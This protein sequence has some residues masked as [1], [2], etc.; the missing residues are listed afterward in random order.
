MPKI[1]VYTT[2]Y[3]PY[4]AAAKTL[5]KNK[6]AKFEE[7]NVE[8]NEEKR[9]WLRETTGQMTVPQIFI[10]DKPIGGYRELVGLEQKGELDGLLVS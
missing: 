2:T 10:N 9:K 7:I 5:L 8:G 4:C 1:T 6:K 3:C